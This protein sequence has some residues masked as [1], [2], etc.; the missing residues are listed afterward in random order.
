MLFLVC[1]VL[2]VCPLHLLVRSR[3]PR[4]FTAAVIVSVF[5]NLCLNL[6]VEDREEWHTESTYRTTVNFYAN[7]GVALLYSWLHGVW[8]GVLLFCAAP[9]AF[10]MGRISDVFL[11]YL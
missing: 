9:I 6:E 5:L 11:G 3:I 1:V 8:Y 7:A 2:F 10:Y 4:D